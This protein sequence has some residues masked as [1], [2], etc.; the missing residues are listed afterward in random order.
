M[1]RVALNVVY[2]PDDYLKHIRCFKTGL[3]E[4]LVLHMELEDTGWSR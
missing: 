4:N 2:K 3:G 1:G